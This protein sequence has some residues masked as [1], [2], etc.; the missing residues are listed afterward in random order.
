[1]GLKQAEEMKVALLINQEFLKWT[2]YWSRTTL[3]DKE[4]SLNIQCVFLGQSP[5]VDKTPKE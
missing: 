1:M 2:Q 4:A 5:K 3:R